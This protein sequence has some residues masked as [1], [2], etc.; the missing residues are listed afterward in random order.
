MSV[1][2]SLGK[3]AKFHFNRLVFTDASYHYRPMSRLTDHLP[4]TR[5]CNTPPPHTPPHAT[6]LAGAFVLVNG[7]GFRDVIGVSLIVTTL[8][9]LFSH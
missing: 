9:F 7:F 1:G 3:S 8:T 6:P 4:K 5:G 2:K